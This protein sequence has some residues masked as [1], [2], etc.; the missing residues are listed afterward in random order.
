MPRI[1]LG[2]QATK[3]GVKYKPESSNATAQICLQ[4]QHL[5]PSSFTISSE[6]CWRVWSKIGYHRPVLHWVIGGVSALVMFEDPEKKG[7]PSDDYNKK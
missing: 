1:A 3:C 4:S 2:D 6:V 7:L 5:G